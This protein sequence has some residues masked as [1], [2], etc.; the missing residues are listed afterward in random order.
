MTVAYNLISSHPGVMS[1]PSILYTSMATNA[2]PTARTSRCQGGPL[3]P[4][5]TIYH[6]YMRTSPSRTVTPVMHTA[7]TLAHSSA[8]SSAK[9]ASSGT[10]DG[11]TRA[12]SSQS[13]ASKMSRWRSGHFSRT[14]CSYYPWAVLQPPFDDVIWDG[15][16]TVIFYNEEP[17]AKHL[18]YFNFT[19][20][21]N[22]IVFTSGEAPRIIYNV[23]AVNAS[24]DNVQY[25]H[26]VTGEADMQFYRITYVPVLSLVALLGIII[27]V[28]LVTILVLATMRTWSWKTFR[29]VD[30]TRLA[31]DR[32]GAD[33]AKHDL[34]LSRLRPASDDELPNRLALV[35]KRLLIFRTWTVVDNVLYD[36]HTPGG[37]VESSGSYQ[38]VRS[39]EQSD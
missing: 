26:N 12:G 10:G 3:R 15:P 34:T 38:T 31:V 21:V 27:S 8:S 11:K 14:G 30:I 35:N 20:A 19:K 17:S 29:Q 28:L 1:S 36:R 32:V 24:R 13:R 39:S 25:F 18:Q 6:Q 4:T 23:A 22:N 16:T 9:K 7:H 37:G 5:R 2:C 33:L